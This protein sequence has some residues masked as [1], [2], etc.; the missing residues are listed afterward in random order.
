MARSLS[1][2]RADI[3]SLKPTEKRELLGVLLAEL[4]HAGEEDVEEAWLLEAQRR[5][6]DLRTGAVKGVPG[7]QVFERLWKNLG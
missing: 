1:E 2:I 6:A 4:E 7:P 5:L 3:S